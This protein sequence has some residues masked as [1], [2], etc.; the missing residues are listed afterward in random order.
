VLNYRAGVKAPAGASPE[1]PDAVT[2]DEIEHLACL[3]FQE[4]LANPSNRRAIPHRFES[5]G[6]T[7]VRNP[8]A[9]D[10]SWVLDG[11]RQTVYAK[12][13]LTLHDQIN[14]VELLVNAQRKKT[15]DLVR[16]GKVVKPSRTKKKVREVVYK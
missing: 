16:I 15:A 13:Q 12:A 9:K 4:W 7:I 6:Y 5:V 3:K 1:Q 8:L 14:A 11:R 2:L 10:G